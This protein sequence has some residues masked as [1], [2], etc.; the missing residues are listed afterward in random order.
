MSL[1]SSQALATR[2]GG[3]KACAVEG[4]THRSVRLGVFDESPTSNMSACLPQNDAL[5][6]VQYLL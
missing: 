5:D 2:H 6:P 1:F 3:G 4:A